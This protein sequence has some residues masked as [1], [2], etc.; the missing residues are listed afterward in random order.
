MGTLIVAGFMQAPYTYP[1]ASKLDSVETEEPKHLRNF[2]NFLL[3]NGFID[4]LRRAFRRPTGLASLAALVRGR[5]GLTRKV[6]LIFASVFMKNKYLIEWF[7][8][9]PNS[10]CL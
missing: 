9:G 5:I 10:A 7:S 4:Y 1:F 3:P 2:S 6:E 8:A